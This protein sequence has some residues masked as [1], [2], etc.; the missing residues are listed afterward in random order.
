[1]PI[2]FS[3]SSNTTNFFTPFKYICIIAV[4]NNSEGPIVITGVVITSPTDISRDD[5]FDAMNLTI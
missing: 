3:L 2:K 1:M 5:G 4:V